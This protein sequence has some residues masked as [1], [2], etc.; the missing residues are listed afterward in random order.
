MP[1]KKF[2][3][4][5][6]I[7][8]V[9]AS[10]SVSQEW[11]TITSP[12]P[13]HGAKMV[14]DARN[15]RMVVFGGGNIRVPWGQFHND[16]WELDLKCRGY[17]WRLLE[18]AG[19]PPCPR[20]FM[21]AVYDSSAQRMIVFGGT[22]DYTDY[23]DDV[24]IL[25]LERGNERWEEMRIHGGSPS[26]RC[27]ATAVYDYAQQRMVVF[28]G[29]DDYEFFNDVW[30]LNP[31]E[32]TWSLLQPMG[33]PPARRN[34]HSAVYDHRQHRMIV[35]AGKSGAGMFDDVW[36]LDLTSHAEEWSELHTTGQA[37]GGIA[38]HVAVYC[39]ASGKMYTFGG[40]DY[41]PFEYPD[42]VFCLDLAGAEWGLVDIRERPFGRRAVCGDFDHRNRRLIIFGGSRYYDYYFGDTHALTI[43]TTGIAEHE[44]APSP[45]LVTDA[46]PNPSNSS[47]AISF[48]I[49]EAGPVSVR[50][51]TPIGTHV[52]TLLDADISPGWHSVNWDGYDESGTP[53]SSGSYFYTITTR[54]KTATKKI[55]L[56]K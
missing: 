52:K 11:T 31:D 3:F 56:V 14:Y 33:T 42:D 17:T 2:F 7:V 51:H 50:I 35:F 46:A 32:Q 49:E 30:C 20:Q 28:G 53:V 12:P 37:P 44:R 45:L 24:W 41:P 25:T 13:R 29:K 43:P 27:G 48:H 36:I 47:S 10:L 8:A 55:V 1:H 19:R 16:V 39:G 22:N 9:L 40:Y 6:A 4:C 54:D 34:T 26:P 15:E 5:P 23:Y 38:S 21:T 18:P